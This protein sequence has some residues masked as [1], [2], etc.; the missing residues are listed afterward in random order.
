MDEPMIWKREDQDS[1][2]QRSRAW[3]SSCTRAG[4]VTVVTPGLGS[5]RSERGWLWSDAER[6][7]GT[8]EMSK[9]SAVVKKTRGTL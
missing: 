6:Q 1:A 8:W 2:V 4:V 9:L 5:R 3:L 7:Q